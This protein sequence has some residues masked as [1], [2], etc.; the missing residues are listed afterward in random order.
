MGKA[1]SPDIDAVEPPARRLPRKRQ[2]VEYGVEP[3]VVADTW[4]VLSLAQALDS[5]ADIAIEDRRW[6]ASGLRQLIA[7]DKP[8]DVFLPG[9]RGTTGLRKLRD[10]AMALSYFE[11][12]MRTPP[13]KAEVALILVAATF[14]ENI[15]TA[16]AAR[17]KWIDLEL[18]AAMRNV[19]PNTR[20]NIVSALEAAY[21]S[22]RGGGQ[23]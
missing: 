4:H 11:L 8:R 17:R 1:K 15:E 6:L 18:Q 2:T 16:R 7:G 12:T 23:G 21:S 5:G 20:A 10:L 3:K 13:E 19:E 9:H 22:R 14:G